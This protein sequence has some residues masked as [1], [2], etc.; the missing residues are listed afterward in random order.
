[1][2]KIFPLSGRKPA[3]RCSIIE[4]FSFLSTSLYNFNPKNAN[5]QRFLTY[6]T[7]FLGF[8]FKIGDRLW[9]LKFAQE[10]SQ[11]DFEL[12]A[13]SNSGDRCQRNKDLTQNK[14]S[15]N[16]RKPFPFDRMARMKGMKWPPSIGATGEIPWIEQ[17]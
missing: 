11:G 9:K 6:S 5:L 17:W 3:K 16:I 15:V 10:S 12:N 14:E 13:F 2:P 7:C 1:M 8:L 4:S